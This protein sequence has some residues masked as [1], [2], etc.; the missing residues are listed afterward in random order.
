M[1]HNCDEGGI[2]IVEGA[3]LEHL[4][5]KLN[6]YLRDESELTTH[7]RLNHHRCASTLLSQEY[8]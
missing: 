3:L 4:S 1:E 8:T 6:T 5:L 2:V 7:H